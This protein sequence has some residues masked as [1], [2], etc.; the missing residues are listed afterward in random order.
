MQ[1]E[2]GKV[3]HKNKLDNNKNKKRKHQKYNFNCCSLATKYKYSRVSWTFPSFD[4]FFAAKKVH[5]PS[6]VGHSKY[7]HEQAHRKTPK[8]ILKKAATR[9]Q[10]TPRYRDKRFVSKCDPVWPQEAFY[11]AVVRRKNERAFFFRVSV[12]SLVC[13]STSEAHSV[14]RCCVFTYTHAFVDRLLWIW[15][16]KS[17]LPHVLLNYFL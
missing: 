11:T 10:D 17:S 6:T 14:W 12:D 13:V 4:W 5:H 16:D 1:C 2:A 3:L 15:N 8:I 9:Q 7:T